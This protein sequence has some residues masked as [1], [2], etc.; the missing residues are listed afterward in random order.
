MSAE[1]VAVPDGV[2]GLIAGELGSVAARITMA[3]NSI[4]RSRHVIRA[5]LAGANDVHLAALEVHFI[6]EHEVLAHIAAE[7]A[8]RAHFFP[9]VRR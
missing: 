9:G 1:P 8:A 4:V 5:S 7:R 2:A 3:V 6:G